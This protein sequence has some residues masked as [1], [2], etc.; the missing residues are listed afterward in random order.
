VR[1]KKAK[2][3]ICGDFSLP[4]GRQVWF[5]LLMGAKERTIQFRGCVRKNTPLDS[6]KKRT[7]TFSKEDLTSKFPDVIKYIEK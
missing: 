4:A 6:N 3:V 2:V 1:Q 7:R 5:F